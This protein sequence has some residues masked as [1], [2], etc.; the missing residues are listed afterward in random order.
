MSSKRR[1]SKNAAKKGCVPVEL[2]K[3]HPNAAGIDIGA[4]EIWVAV[5]ADRS[6]TPI[7]RFLTFT[8]DLKQMAAWLKECGVDTVAMEST[9]VLWISLFQI[10]ADSG[11]EVLLVNA[12]QY[13]NVPGRR[14]DV[15][16]CQWL[17]YL[18]SVGLVRSSYLPAQAV[19]A[20]RTLCRHREEFT[21]MGAQHVQHI[22]KAMDQMNLKLQYVISDITGSSGQR[23]LDAILSGRRDPEELADLRDRRIKATKEQVRESLVGDYR[24]EH[25][26][27]LR[28]SLEMWRDYEQRIAELD[29]A[30]EPFMAKLEQETGL[31]GP[32]PPPRRLRS[33]KTIQQEAIRLH[34][35]RSFGVDLT[36]IPSIG[37][38]TVQVLLSE[39]GP[40]L[41]KFSS[42]SAFASWPG[43]CPSHEISGGKVLSRRTKK[44]TSRVAVALRVAAQS[45]QWNKSSLGD[46]FR[47]MK[48]KLGPAMANT[49]AA[50]KLARIIYHLVTTAEAYS[51]KR[52]AEDHQPDLQR[53]KGRLER[54]ARALGYQLVP[55][56]SC[57]ERVV[58]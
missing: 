50:H 33:S 18:H 51:E 12:R 9:G 42:A 58:P 24:P 13:Q 7:R 26:F 32:L 31:I 15:Q 19:R 52:F 47:R 43:L 45:L 14:T 22:H 17:Q 4:E 11:L 29:K 54:S 46:W 28:Q 53:R 36:E 3:M 8:N 35:H 10:L 37:I 55:L 23:I 56:G 39:L 57:S 5:P 49:A 20:L 21:R 1:G 6:A 40:D 34:C 30:M 41:S 44:T 2:P 38:G 27:T 16:D 48:A 25:L